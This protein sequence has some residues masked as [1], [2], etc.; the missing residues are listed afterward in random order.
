MTVL[1]SSASARHGSTVFGAADPALAL[2]G[3]HHLVDD[4]QHV[5]DGADGQDTQ[6]H[7]GHNGG[8]AF[9]PRGI[10]DQVVLGQGDAK[11]RQTD[12]VDKG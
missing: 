12:A 4:A 10:A 8:E 3:G 1:Q 7:K 9:V 6:L 5:E 2:D 11:V